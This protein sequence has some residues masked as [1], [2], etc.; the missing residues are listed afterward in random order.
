MFFA[1]GIILGKVKKMTLLKLG[2]KVDVFD[3][4]EFVFAFGRKHK[5]QLNKLQRKR[6]PLM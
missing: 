4:G 5:S 3:N 6:K 1:G 2:K